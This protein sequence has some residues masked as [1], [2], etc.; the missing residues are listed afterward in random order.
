MFF[1]ES[2]PVI[3]AVRNNYELQ[4][5]VKTN[6]SVIFL[7]STNILEINEQIEVIHGYEKSVFIHIDLAEGIGKDNYGL[8]FIKQCKAD[9]II[10]TRTNLIK[11]AK[12]IGLKTVQRFFIVDSHSIDTALE[13][14]KISGADMVEIMPGIIPSVMK[15]LSHKLSVKMIAGGLIDTKQQII[16][17][18]NAGAYAVS[19][20]KKEL[21]YL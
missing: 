5:A 6:C 19:T 17:A 11:A 15:V 21:W 16:E 10:S 1:L 8:N 9:G 20:S 13:S 18:I 7:L 4:Q 3:A 14:S 2:N 12:E